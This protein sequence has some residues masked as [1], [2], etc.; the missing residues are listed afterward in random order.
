MG[1]MSYETD[2]M[3]VNAYLVCLMDQYN[4]KLN[5]WN[6]FFFNS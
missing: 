2:V 6:E 4:N 5:V 1:K 3:F